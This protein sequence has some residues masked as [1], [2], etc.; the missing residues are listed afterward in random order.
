M[1]ELGQINPALALPAY[2]QSMRRDDSEK[3]RLRTLVEGRG[4]AD[5]GI[6]GDVVAPQPSSGIGRRATAALTGSSRVEPDG[7]E[8]STSCLQ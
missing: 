5:N 2:R 4:A 7:I 6:R 8:P 1:D 3:A